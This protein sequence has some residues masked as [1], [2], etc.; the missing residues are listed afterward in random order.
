MR[1]Q[2]GFTLI[3]L[4]T[5]IVVLGILA[6]FAI[7]RFTGLESQARIATVNGLAGNLRSG[8]ALAH[9]LWMAAG[10][11]PSTVTME[12]GT[13]VAMNPTSGYPTGASGG[14]D[15]VIQDLSGFA[16][17]GTRDFKLSNAPSSGNN[18]KVTYTEPTTSGSAPTVATDVTN[19]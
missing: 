13:S 7:P 3:E 15:K 12:G 1:K 4:I 9:A 17:S 11:S 14:I 19:C 18:C 8:A 5:V 16:A 10:N 6:A 2:S